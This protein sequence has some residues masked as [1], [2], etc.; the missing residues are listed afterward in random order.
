MRVPHARA[1]AV[2]I[3]GG[4]LVAT[5]LLTAAP[6]LA[7]G[8][9]LSPDTCPGEVFSVVKN[10]KTCTAVAT[11]TG[12]NTYTYTLTSGDFVSTFEANEFS[13][14]TFKT[15]R[16]QKGKGPIRTT[17]TILDEINTRTLVPGTEECQ[18][19]VIGADGIGVNEPR[20]VADCD[21]LGLYETT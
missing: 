8:T 14:I 4:A 21:A 7:A 20:P 15:V 17:E 11:I 3:A 5:P 6:A 12:N 16:T 13:S 9:V 10:V 19:F 18:E 2:A 1:A